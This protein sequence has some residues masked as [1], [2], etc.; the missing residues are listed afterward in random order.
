[1]YIVYCHLNKI[2]QKRYIG[3]TCQ[4]PQNRWGSQ[5]QR[6]KDSPRFW[7]AI[8]K[9]GWDNFEHQILANGLNQTEAGQLEQ[10]YIQYY[11]T[12]N[13]QYGYNLTTGG[14]QH[15][16]F[17]PEV[18]E[19]ISQNMTGAKNHRYGTHKTEIEKQ[20]M[21]QLF[22]GSKNPAARQVQC[23]ETGIVYG[24]ARDAAEQI[25]KDRIAGGK[26]ISRCALG[27]RETAYG[28]HW[29][30]VNDIN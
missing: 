15:Y 7:Q 23:L 25:G 29:R 28:Y 13:E 16:S 22:S 26:S 4:L 21:R 17:T 2:N 20:H 14:E 19:K 10:Y 3:V 12:T 9:Y 8:Q 27:Q 24:C 6:Y 5:G 1:M 18:R 30:Y 11:N